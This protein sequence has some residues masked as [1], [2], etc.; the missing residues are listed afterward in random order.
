MEPLQQARFGRFNRFLAGP[1]PGAASAGAPFPRPQLVASSP[2]A[3]DKPP[4]LGDRPPASM[5]RARGT[6]RA[7]RKHPDQ[8]VPEA[9]IWSEPYVST[10]FPG[11]FFGETIP[12][13]L[14]TRQKILVLSFIYA[15]GRVVG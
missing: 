14:L 3:N 8:G 2:A 11:D 6:A 15:V 4:P 12:P 13:R 7:V 1:G 10:N 9:R 5:A